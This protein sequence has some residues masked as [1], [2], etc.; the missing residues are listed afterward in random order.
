MHLFQLLNQYLRPN[1]R[2]KPQQQYPHANF[3][4]APANKVALFVLYCLFNLNSS[5]HA[6]DP[7]K[8]LHLSFPAAET[9][10]D[11]VATSDLYSAYVNYS[12]FE[13]L[14]TYDY[15]ARPPRLIPLTAS[16]LPT[17]SADGKTYTIHIKKGIYFQDDPVFKGKK[18]ELRAYDYAY[19]L[20]RLLDPQLASPNA[21]LLM[22]KLKG[23]EQ[24]IAAAKASKHFDYDAAVEGIQ[25]P[26]PYTLVLKLNH[27]D[28][29]LPFMLA[30]TPSVAVAREVIEKYKD[31]RGT[32]M[33]HPVGTG[34]YRLASWT[35]GSRIKLT[36]N[37]DYRGYI[38]DFKA[39]TDPVD[40][41][42]VAAMKG[43]KMPQIGTVDIQVIEDAQSQW[44]AFKQHQLDYI[45]LSN[46]PIANVVIR[47][48]QL[49]PDLVKAGV[50]LSKIALPEMQYAFFNMQDPIVGGLSPEKI[51]LRRAIFM[52]FSK[53]NYN[54]VIYTGSA[55]I[56]A[57]PVATTVAGYDASYQS[58]LPY[59]V[60]AANL[61]LDRYHYKI[62]ADGYR[63]LPNGQALTIEYVMVPRG[64]DQSI[65][66]F[67]KRSL[68]QIHIRFNTK[69]MLFPDYLKAMKQCKVQMS[70]YN[71][72]ADYPDA[73]N[74]F[75]LFNGSDKA[76]ELGCA[77]IP[78]F[79]QRYLQTQQLPDGPQ[80]RILYQQMAR[81]LDHYAYVNPL[82]IRSSNVLVHPRII[83]YKT[84]PMTM[85]YW[86]YL[87]IKK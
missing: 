5:A 24:L 41:K 56:N 84:H 14:Y 16:A 7:K 40:T 64:V 6:A 21:W 51:A 58:T 33:A 49:A 55:T 62:A 30:H 15:L 81:L 8:V 22:G 23:M 87:D 18:R 11:P 52:A 83:G 59:S 54:R 19:S 50:Y 86:L 28:Y 73:D 32:V 20:K 44:L 77:V 63:R 67:W 17:I 25:T 53:D 4:C 34:A 3:G 76:S 69:T 2:P 66:E 45:D 68:E 46:G 80:R 60:S 75:M 65:A 82:I 36:A 71:W 10:F 85:P 31:R 9:G 42:I 12:I 70:I 27:S 29:N 39:G 13:P 61:L 78:E 35:P 38:W 79:D 74:F 43:K 72:I 26:D 47:D 1:L 48:G 57:Y 37:A